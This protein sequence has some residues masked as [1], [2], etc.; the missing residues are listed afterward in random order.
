M[1]R[2]HST[3][4]ILNFSAVGED[5]QFVGQNVTALLASISKKLR[6]CEY[7]STLKKN[8][9]ALPRTL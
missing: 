4:I 2:E 3:R 1:G 8:S 5:I 9:K 6:R 7:F